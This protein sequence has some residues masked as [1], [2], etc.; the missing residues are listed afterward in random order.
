M[1]VDNSEQSVRAVTMAVK[2]AK[3]SII[4]SVV[5]FNVYDSSKVDITKLHS[6]E[7][8]D[9]LRAASMELLQSYEKLF[10]AEGISCQLKKAGGQPAQLIL[11]LIENSGDFDL[12][13][14]G[15]RRLNKFQE[16]TMGSVSDK[17]TRLAKVPV[18]IVK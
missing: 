17:V 10:K 16:F 12:V 7:K 9:K 15:S 13:M 8:L 2:M 4:G 6:A 3:A 18:L 11:D 14:I 1:A 5:L